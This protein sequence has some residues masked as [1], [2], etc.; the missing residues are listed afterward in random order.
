MLSPR[1]SRS[2]MTDVLDYAPIAATILA[3]PQFLPQIVRLRGTGDAAGLSWA[4]AMLTSLNNAAWIGYF[5]L[6][7]YWS[8]LVPAIAATLLAGLLALL[9]SRRGQAD[10]RS[11]CLI[12]GWAALL[13]AA[14]AL[15]GRAGLGALLTAAF[16]I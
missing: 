13:A 11:A 14:G 2:A 10:V 9:L 16:A 15:S 8:A 4:W 7:R 12:T 3:I 6:A 5:A 1:G